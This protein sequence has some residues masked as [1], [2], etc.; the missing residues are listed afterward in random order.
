MQSQTETSPSAIRELSPFFIVGCG[1]SGTT[2]LRTMLNHHP[3]VAIPL[4]SL[5]IIDYF[6]A[7]SL[8]DIDRF[9]RLVLGEYELS[10][11][12]MPVTSADLADCQT[13]TELIN[14][15]HELY[16]TQQ[17]KTIWGQKTPRFVR[18][19]D[20]LKTAYLQSRFVHVLR[21]PRAVT[22]SLI[23]SN[24]HNSNAYF[25]AHR[26][27][28]DVQAGLALR[29]QYPEDVLEITYE[30]LVSDTEPVLRQVCDFL[31]LSFDPA[32]LTYYETG[33]AEYS[34]YYAQIHTRLNQPPNKE[35][36]YAWR[37][38]L[39]DEE[40][41]LVEHICGAVMQPLGYE[42]EAANVIV[43]PETIQRLKRQR[44]VG[45][46]QQIAHYLTKRRR[47]LFYSLWRKYRLGLLFKDTT[48]V[49]Y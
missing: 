21:D 1:R 34:P 14:R 23:R 7:E 27:L 15:L 17:G 16:L 29:E 43:A 12:E 39:S 28:K 13:L 2:L 47:H 40:I 48:Q 26:W 24:V 41:A 45:F 11:W 22:S 32:M 3:A 46:L 8:V 30:D 33:Q 25:A 20:L 6:R 31:G 35:R 49:N 18:Y 5:F 42:L 9:R 44:V 38:N 4:E 10:E 37:K 36:I 19:G